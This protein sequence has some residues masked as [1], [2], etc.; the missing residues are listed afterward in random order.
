M[1]I[2]LIVNGSEWMKMAGYWDYV[3]TLVEFSYTKMSTDSMKLAWALH[4]EIVKCRVSI[5]DVKNFD[6]LEFH[7]QVE[8]VLSAL[9]KGEALSGELGRS[10]KGSE[11][12]K[13]W[14]LIGGHWS[15][16]AICI[17]FSHLLKKFLIRVVSDFLRLFSYLSDIWLLTFHCAQIESNWKSI[18]YIILIFKEQIS[19]T[20]TYYQSYSRKFLALGRILNYELWDGMGCSMPLGSL[21]IWSVDC[22][23]RQWSIC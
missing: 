4:D 1:T 14:D 18:P 10:F 6:R 21:G 20:R 16:H 8:R 19:L 7:G 22:L 11:R 3:G 23:H 12:E 5:K 9:K 13:R 17:I 15:P 2:S